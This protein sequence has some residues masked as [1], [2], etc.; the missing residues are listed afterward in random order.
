MNYFK[1]DR[2]A[3]MIP[4]LEREIKIFKFAQ[5][6]P[7]LKL[8]LLLNLCIFRTEANNGLF[9]HYHKPVLQLIELIPR[10]S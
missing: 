2:S 9:G 5:D 10:T 6:K 7:T 3:K 1:T 8:A 4:L